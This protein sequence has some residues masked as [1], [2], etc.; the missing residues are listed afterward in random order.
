[1][2]PDNIT[3]RGQRISLRSFE[4]EQDILN[5]DDAYLIIIRI[6]LS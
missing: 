6:A 3:D 1:M 4:N 2:L 5:L